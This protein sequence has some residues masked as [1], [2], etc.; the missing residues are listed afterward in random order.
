MEFVEVCSED[1]TNKYSFKRYNGRPFHMITPGNV[2]DQ[3]QRFAEIQCRENDVLLCTYPRSGTHW[4][5]NT[6]QMLRLGTLTYSGTPIVADFEDL[7]L[8]EQIA[9]PRTFLTHFTF[10]LI[11]T[12]AKKGVPKVIFV[13]RNPKDVLVSYFHFLD[14]MRNTGFE[15][16][17]NFFVKFFLSEEYFTS[18]ASWFTYMKEWADGF[19]QHPKMRVLSIAYEDFKKDTFG[20]IVKLADFLEVQKDPTFLREVEKNVT[21]E[22]LKEGHSKITGEIDRWSVVDKNGRVP[23]YR[24]GKVGDWKNMFTVAQNEYFDA[25]YLEKM[26]GYEFAFEYE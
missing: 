22:H 12:D 18:G 15:G 10:P 24:K 16:D 8:I 11:P 6:V 13:S 26:A 20:S 14:N 7:K 1:K 2:R 17:F 21:F 23:I 4:V 19:K 5:Y 9:T 25:V 3:L